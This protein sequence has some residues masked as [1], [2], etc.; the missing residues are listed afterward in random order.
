MSNPYS[1]RNLFKERANQKK[2]AVVQIAK[3]VYK[4]EANRDLELGRVYTS[5]GNTPV[6]PTYSIGASG[7][8]LSDTAQGD[9][10]YLRHGSETLPKSLSIRG[11]IDVGLTDCKVRMIIFRSLHRQST[12]LSHALVLDQTELGNRSYVN[13]PLT[14]DNTE[15]N[16]IEVLTDRT[17]VMNNNNDTRHFA[18]NMKLSKRKKFYYSGTALN[19][20]QLNSIQIMFVSDCS[21]ANGAEVSYTSMLRFTDP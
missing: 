7:T 13:A 3:Q 18:I 17:Y 9:Q 11:T 19:S 21:L 15:R 6:V 10:A 1:K 5:T 4:R 8:I 12:G 16:M 2:K 14:F 20:E